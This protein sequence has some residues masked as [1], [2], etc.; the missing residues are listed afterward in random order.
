MIPQPYSINIDKLGEGGTITTDTCNA[1]QKVR[2]LLVE[3]INGHLNGQY[4]MQHVRNVWINGV[5]KAVNKYM[6]EFLNKSLDD[7]SSYLCVPLSRPTIQRV[8][9]SSPGPG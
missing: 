1:A 2:R 5:A 9:A 4:C 6:T 8:T 7:I 3:D